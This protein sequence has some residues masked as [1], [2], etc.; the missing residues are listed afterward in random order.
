[1]LKFI[2][3]PLDARRVQFRMY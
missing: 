2:L 1:M 3:P